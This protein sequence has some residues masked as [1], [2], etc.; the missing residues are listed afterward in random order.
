[1]VKEMMERARISP[2]IT[3]IWHS[4]HATLLKPIIDSAKLYINTLMTRSKIR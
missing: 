4:H 3:Y 1:M 2:R